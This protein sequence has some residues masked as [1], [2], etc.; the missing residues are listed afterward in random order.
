MEITHN[1]SLFNRLQR[2]ISE[3]LDVKEEIIQPNSTWEKLGA[4]SLDRLQMTRA[5]EEAFTVEIPHTVGETLNTVGETLD[6]LLTLQAQ[7]EM[8]HRQDS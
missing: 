6:H 2:I 5:I 8:V 7:V 1:Q 4:D 3:Q